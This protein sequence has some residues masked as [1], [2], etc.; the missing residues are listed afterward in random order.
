VFS[1]EISEE[2]GVGTVRGG[3]NAKSEIEILRKYCMVF[4]S[5]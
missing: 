2:V 1:P 4:F 5:F 3:D